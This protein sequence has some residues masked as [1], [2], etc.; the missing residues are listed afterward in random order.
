MK[1]VPLDQ[2]KEMSEKERMFLNECGIK[3]GCY[4]AKKNDFII[5]VKC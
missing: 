1:F 4:D 2:I 3:E 5:K